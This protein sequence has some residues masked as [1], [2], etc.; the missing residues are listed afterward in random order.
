MNFI[1]VAGFALVCRL[2]VQDEAVGFD[3]SEVDMRVL[4]NLATQKTNKF[5]Q[6]FVYNKIGAVCEPAEVST[7]V[8][9]MTM[10]KTRREGAKGHEDRAGADKGTRDLT[11]QERHPHT[12]C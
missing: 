8:G 6:G 12:G 2:P 10:M 11:R 5:V 7:C 1:A 3:S 4:G 9:R